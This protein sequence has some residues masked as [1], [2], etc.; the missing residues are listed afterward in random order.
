MTG[1]IDIGGGMRDIYGAGAADCFLDLGVK[2]DLCIGVSAG[3]A[4][5]ASF[6]A[7]Q[8]G[9]NYR[10]YSVYGSRKEYMSVGNYLRD[11]S[12]IDLNYIY[13]TLSD[14]DGEDPIDFDAI[15]KSESEIVIVATN[16]ETGEAEYFSKSEIRRNDLWLL[17]ASSAIPIVCRPHEREGKKYFD[18]GVAD[19][20]PLRKAFEMG[21]ERVA[22]IIPRPA[23]SKGKEYLPIMKTLL[24]DYPNVALKMKERSSLYNRELRLVYDYAK[25]GKVI[26]ISP[27]SD[28]GL[29]MLTTNPEK[30]RAYYRKGYNDAYSA[31]K[32]YGLS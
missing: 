6:A 7:G 27:D 10:F 15:K 21:C 25:S 4:N 18:G 5:V 1:L 19:P 14:E 17:K 22:V 3:S 13:S 32:K 20:I 11:G 28:K 8:R 31:V 9:R 16:A 24:R 2:F 29:N 23:V 26:L 30:L 12:Y